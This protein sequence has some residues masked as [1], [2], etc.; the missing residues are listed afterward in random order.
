MLRTALIALALVLAAA[1][2][3]KAPPEKRYEVVSVKP[4]G[5]GITAGCSF[6]PTTFSSPIEFTVSHCSIATLIDYAY[7]SFAENRIDGVPNWARSAFYSVS[8]KSASP[9]QMQ[10]KYAML[11]PLLEERFQLKG[12]REKR[13]LPVYFLSI[14]GKL[15]LTKTAPGS[16]RSWDPKA[17]PAPTLDPKL[18]PVCT[19]WINRILP[20][21]AHTLQANGVTLSALALFVGSQLGR[22]GVDRTNSKDLFDV[23]IEFAP[24]DLG[25]A[26]DTGNGLKQ[27]APVA[28]D[29]LGHP[30]IFTALKNVGL[31]LTP[32]RAPL[33][34]F[35]VD[36]VQRPGEN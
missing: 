13:E 2:Q 9:A 34:V 31:K 1:A 36:S 6:S 16:C 7:G 35:V 11:Q 29:P 14:D 23:H 20:D 15:K 8:A 5:P 25:H 17:G 21:G 24:P 26:A 18:P 4:D 28:S 33:E 32:G 19:I 10:E 30:S 12:H 27:P 22:D 3:I